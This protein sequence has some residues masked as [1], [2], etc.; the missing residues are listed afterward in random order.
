MQ[1]GASEHR[2][3]PARLRPGG[4]GRAGH[5]LVHHVPARLP[6]R[7]RR[8]RALR[9]QLRDRQLALDHDRAADARARDDAHARR[10]PPA[11]ADVDHR[12][13]ARDRRRSRRWSGSSSASGSPRGSSALFDVVGFTLPNNGLTFATRTIVVSIMVGVARRADREPASC[14]PCD[15]GAADR[16]RARGGDAAAVALRALPHARIDPAH[17]RRVRSAPLRALRQRPEHDGDPASG[18]ASARC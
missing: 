6:A 15:A 11:G 8:D 16:R 10:E 5:Q 3:G 2:P 14:D 7:V 13:G 18:W 12:R 4:E 17:R 1:G 9:R